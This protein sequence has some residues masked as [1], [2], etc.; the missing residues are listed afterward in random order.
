MIE[1]LAR[2]HCGILTARYQTALDPSAWPVRACQCSFCRSHGSL[3]TSDPAGVLSFRSS[4]AARVQRY[5]F[6]ARCA[7]FLVCRECEVYVGVQMESDQGRLGVLNTLALRP[8]L[9]GL[10]APAPM[11]YGAETA[12][13]RRLRREARWTP[14][15]A[16]SL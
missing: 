7:D 3:A 11:D 1:Y 15:A 13:V 10:P 16:M 9:A 14:V 2:C 6:G 8:L 12:E 4:D 5:R